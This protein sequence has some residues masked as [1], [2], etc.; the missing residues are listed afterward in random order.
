MRPLSSRTR[1][2][3]SGPSSSPLRRG[4]STSEVYTDSFW[5]VALLA[6]MARN[7]A[8]SVM[9]GTTF[10]T[11]ITA[12]CTRGSEV[13]MRPLPSLVTRTTV[14]VSATAKFAPVMPRSAFRNF[15]RSSSR[16]PREHL[17][18]GAGLALEL[19]GEQLG[20]L[21]LRLVDGRRDDVRGALVGQLD[22]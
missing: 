3:S 9:E 1:W 2:N 5:P 22:D 4:P 16:E 7:T 12:T 10:S 14:P 13:A 8:R 11:P 6:R 20:H 15:S 21:P 18:I 19:P 17:G